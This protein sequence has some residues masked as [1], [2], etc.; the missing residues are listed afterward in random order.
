M[1]WKMLPNIP[2]QKLYNQPEII[3]QNCDTLRLNQK[4]HGN[5]C[6]TLSEKKLFGTMRSLR[7][8]H[9]LEKAKLNDSRSELMNQTGFRG[10]SDLMKYE[11]CS[12]RR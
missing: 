3:Q 1:N 5:R 2:N 7:L 8:V 4:L 10:R 12:P 11:A 6:G 9:M